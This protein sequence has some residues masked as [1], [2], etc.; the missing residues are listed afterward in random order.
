MNKEINVGLLGFGMAGRI[1]HAPFITAVPG[2]HLKKIRANREESIQLAETSYPEARIVSDTQEILSDE[3]IDLVVVATSNATHFSHAKAALQAG[4]H[5]L[6]DKPFT[7]TLAEADELIELA[8]TQQKLLTV[9]QNRRWDSDFKTVKKVVEHNVLGNLVE[10]EAHFDRFRNEIKPNTWKEEDLPGSGLLH[11]LGSHLIDQALYLFGNPEEI[12]ADIRIQRLNSK[13]ID[14][15]ELILQ[16]ESLKVTLKA[17]MLVRELGPH[18]ILLGEKGAFVKYGMDVQ[19]DALKTGLT[20]SNTPV[21]GVEPEEIW[22]TL[23]TE[24]DGLH[25]KGRIESETGDYR[26]LYQNVYKAILGEEELVVKP[27]Q[28]RNTMKLIELALQ[29]S[30]EKRT[31]KFS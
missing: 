4:K 17:G 13:I 6:I 21:W 14:N 26:G 20:P 7:T 23:N 5:V 15:F 24:I 8:K 22:G 16:Y 2:L 25:F 9:F 27:G 31:V 12:M 3:E 29:S 1:F 11:D 10:Y 18:F 19:E 28:A 30:K